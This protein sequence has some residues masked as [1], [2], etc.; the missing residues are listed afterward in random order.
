M[1]DIEWFRPE[2][3]RGVE[4][5]Y[6]RT[7]GTEAADSIRLRWDW[8]RRNPA[9]LAG[10]PSFLVVRE[11]P[12]VIAAAPLTTVRAS[13]RGLDAAGAWCGDPLVAA[14]RQRQGLG[15]AL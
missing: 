9:N 6:R 12:T 1:A 4:Q 7:Y 10:D 5:L 3:R 11:G 13:L 2:D 8:A 14:E 15:E